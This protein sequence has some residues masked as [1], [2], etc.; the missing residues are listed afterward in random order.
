MKCVEIQG[1]KLVM[2]ERPALKPKEGE[3]LVKVYA[4]GVNRPD[5]MQRKG[6]Y[7]PPPGVTD[8][9]GLEIAGEIAEIGKGVR[10]FKTGQKVCALVAGGG[11][12][13]YCVAHFTHVLP[14]PAGLDML[15][16]AGIPETFFTVWTNLFDLAHLKKG[17][18]LLVHGGTSG[19]GTTAIQ[20]ARAFGAR[21]FITAGTDVKCKAAK[22]IGAH[23]AIN[24]RTQDFVTEVLKATKNKGVDAVLDMIGGSYLTRNMKALK[25][26]G[27]HVSI[28]AQQGRNAEIDIISLMQ[29]RLTLTGSTLRPRTVKE[30]ALI[31]KALQKNIWPLL[32]RKNALFGLFSKKRITP[33]IDRVFALNEAQQAHDYI[34][35][36]AHV[37]KVILRVL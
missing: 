36:G 26:G 5:V 37:G 30:K 15:T 28:A 23:L 34:E 4:A 33:V 22:K 10:G 29:K 32:K 14:V 6:Y 13:E 21:V 35:S 24:Y 3:V 18:T 31:A 27:R 20:I 9:P 25:P 19:I 8:I 12:A 16:A 17:E 7:P 1:Q 11:Y 2:A